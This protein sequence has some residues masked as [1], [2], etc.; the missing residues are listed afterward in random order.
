MSP[1]DFI[2]SNVYNVNVFSAVYTY[3]IDYMYHLALDIKIQ[4]FSINSLI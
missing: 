2:F 1:L 3:T 4:I